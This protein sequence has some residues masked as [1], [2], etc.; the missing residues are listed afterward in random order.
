MKKVLV[1]KNKLLIEVEQS[2][3]GDERGCS[4]WVAM[5]R[6]YINGKLYIDADGVDTFYDVYAWGHNGVVEVTLK[7]TQDHRPDFKQVVLDQFDLKSYVGLKCKKSK[8]RLFNEWSKEMHENEK[9]KYFAKV[10]WKVL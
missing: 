8:I 1:E 10:S 9:S 7:Y 3:L 4:G 5:S 6:L 2:D